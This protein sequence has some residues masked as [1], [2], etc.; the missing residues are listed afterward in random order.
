MKSVGV[1]FSLVSIA[2]LFVASGHSSADSLQPSDGNTTTPIKHVIVIIGENRS[3]D[4]IFGTY[5]PR[6]DQSVLLQLL[7]A[8]LVAFFGADTKLLAGLIERVAHGHEFLI[9]FKPHDTIRVCETAML[10]A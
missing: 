7:S 8:F 10:R 3:F 5:V 2:I 1:R 9:V 4:H 6:P